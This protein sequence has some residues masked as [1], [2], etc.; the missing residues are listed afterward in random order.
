LTPLVRPLELARQLGWC[1]AVLTFEDNDTQFI[2]YP[3]PDVKPMQN[4]LSAFTQVTC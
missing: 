1:Q 4:E 2:V 3:F